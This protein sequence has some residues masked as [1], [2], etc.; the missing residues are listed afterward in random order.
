[1]TRRRDVIII[2]AGN[3]G[4]ALGRVCRWHGLPS[5]VRSARRLWGQASLS[6]G[7]PWLLILAVRDAE[8]ASWAERLSAEPTALKSTVVAHVAG[9][10][11][12]EILAPLRP[13]CAGIAQMH[14]LISFA[15]PTWVPPLAGGHMHVT[16]DAE[17]MRRCRHLA[18]RIGMRPRTMANLDLP[19]YHAAAALVANGTA[20]LA[21]AGAQ[22]LLRAGADAD[23]VPTM[24]GA[25]LTSVAATISTLGLPA[26]LTGPV[27][28][29]DASAVALH[30]AAITQLAPE[31]AALYRALARAQ[32]PMATML[33]NASPASLA[34]IERALS[35]VEN[36]HTP[37]PQR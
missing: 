23:A 35:G 5:R 34:A 28:R 10:L 19:A 36:A 2:G 29:G 4:T 9:R 16:G 14:P 8:I 33:S 13:F 11:P 27:R 17:A 21:H 15:N 7:R 18:Q 1:V 20:A 37:A 32:I 31:A 30:L 22:L 12:A 3:V 24:L 25:L 26:A 6:L